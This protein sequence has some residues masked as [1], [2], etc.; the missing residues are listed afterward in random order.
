VPNLLSGIVTHKQKQRSNR[1]FYPLSLAHSFVSAAAHRP[2]KETAIV[3]PHLEL[4][5][6]SPAIRE[7][8][9]EI[10]CAARSDAKVLITGES[11]VGK[12]VVARAIHRRSRRNRSRLVAIN[13]AGVPD[14]LLESELFGHAR[15][16]FTDAYRDKK[17]WLEQAHFGTIFLDEIGEMSLRMQALLLRFLENGEIQ[18]VGSDRT[19]ATVDV[20]VIAAT[21]R[22]L[23]DRIAEKEFREDLYYRL[24]VIHIPVPALRDRRQ[25]VSALLDHF[26]R[27][28]SAAH[29]REVPAISDDAMQRLLEYEWRGNVRELKNF[30]ERLVIRAGDV[31]RVN[32]LP[33]EMAVVAP[34]V[35]AQSHGV[36]SP[37]DLLFDRMVHNGESFWS[38][39]YQPFMARDFTRRDLRA[40][41]GRGLEQTR[42]NYKLLVQL[43]N[44]QPA[45]YKR[46]LS[47]LRK[48]E[49]H[50]PFQTFRAIP[51]RAATTDI[52]VGSNRDV[53]M[54]N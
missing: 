52:T 16:A 38:V 26:I 53:R 49:C 18:R 30:V 33:R 22:N 31:I 25:D 46:L 39:V 43:F 11:G 37:V 6:N 10:D 32:D 14:S 51:A 21:N 27:V 1:E 19:T 24:N 12:E 41:V 2:V 40:I 35:T 17:G 8:M 50:L 34:K 48:Y 7:I 3:E 44:L 45:E 15:G 29:R 42:G 47:F 23:L 5:G 28:F 9:D 36:G 4:I 20:R 54:Q 13:C